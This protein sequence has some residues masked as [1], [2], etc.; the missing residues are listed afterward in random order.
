[1]LF[2]GL[3][4]AASA[5]A[6]HTGP[7]FEASEAPDA[8]ILQFTLHGMAYFDENVPSVRIYGDGTVEVFRPFRMKDRPAGRFQMH[9]ADQE[10]S[11]L[12]LFLFERGALE[13]STS[14]VDRLK[15]AAEDEYRSVHGQAPARPSDS[16]GFVLRIALERFQR[17][18]DSSPQI[19]FEHVVAVSDAGLFAERYP[20]HPAF[21]DLKEVQE[22]FLEYMN[23][24][25]L[26]NAPEVP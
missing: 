23:H 14:D 18:S 15:G 7:I 3:A 10:L 8:V 26:V 2:G 5:A 19:N 13:T 16:G 24:P 21:S 20:E 6:A 25:E 9:L 1:M 4:L 17:N 11:D 22:R 12:V